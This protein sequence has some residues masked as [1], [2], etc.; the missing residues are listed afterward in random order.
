VI[1][2]FQ[3]IKHKCADM[4][5]DVEFA[6]SAAYRAAELV[7]NDSEELQEAACIAKALASD[8]FMQAATDTLQIHG[9]IGFTWDNDTQLYYKRARG[10]GALLGSAAE[11]RDR[12]VLRLA[13]RAAGETT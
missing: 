8:A 10:S 11:H 4:L 13:A 9:G 12:Y 6:R 5:L 1:G 7:A 2:S 3:A